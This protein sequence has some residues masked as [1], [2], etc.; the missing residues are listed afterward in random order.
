ML[1]LPVPWEL[2]R[3]WIGR[4]LRLNI[5]ATLTSIRFTDPTVRDLAAIFVAA[6][7][8]DLIGLDGIGADL[9]RTNP[10]AKYHLLYV[11]RRSSAEEF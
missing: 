7:F 4:T 9:D 5:P 10:T 11:C 6:R 2:I 3:L 8:P 1:L